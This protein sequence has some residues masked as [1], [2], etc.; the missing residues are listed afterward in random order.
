MWCVQEMHRQW[1][2]QTNRAP[3]LGYSQ[4]TRNS[5][6]AAGRLT[7]PALGFSSRCTCDHITECLFFTKMESVQF[8]FQRAYKNKL[9]IACISK[10]LYLAQ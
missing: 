9:F 2:Y 6:V 3:F 5:S 1:K 10:L 7:R 8:S 4:K